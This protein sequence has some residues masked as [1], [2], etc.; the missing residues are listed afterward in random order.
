MLSVVNSTKDTWQELGFG[1]LQKS[2]ESTVLELASNREKG[3]VARS[4]LVQLTRE[5]RKS[6]SEETKKAVLALLKSFQAEVDA[7]RKR[8][9]YAEDAYIS[10]YKKLIDLPDPTLAL[11]E[12]QNLQ[13]KASRS[14]DI[15]CEN[16]KLRE[17]N[18]QLRSEVSAL[19]HHE[20][21]AARLQ[22][23]LDDLNSNMESELKSR[24]ASLEENFKKTVLE[25]EQE[26]IV[27]R[28]EMEEKHKIMEEK[29]VGLTKALEMTQS[30][31]FTLKTQAD[32][33]ESGKTSELEILTD[34]LDKAR[35]RIR[36]LE[37]SLS[38][39][40]TGR[41][42]NENITSQ[43]LILTSRVEDLESDLS[44]KETEISLY[45]S[46]L[47]VLRQEKEEVQS[48]LQVKVEELQTLITNLETQ[49][50]EARVRLQSQSDYEE[51]C[52]ELAFLRSIEF[53]D[54]N[55]ISER[56]EPEGIAQFD[57]N[58]P[59]ASAPVLK[60]PL[61]VLLMNKNRALQNQIA[62]L[63]ATTDQ[64]RAELHRLQ[65]FEVE[66]RQQAQEQRELIAVL[67][68]DLYRL[69]EAYDEAQ[70]LNMFGQTGT[71]SQDSLHTASHAAGRE[72][73]ILAEAIGE[74]QPN[75]TTVP[76]VDPSLLQIVVHQRDRFRAR[77]EELEQSES[78]HKQQI[79]LLQRE[80]ESVRADNVK[81]YG[82]IRF[83][84]SYSSPR[85]N[86]PAPESTKSTSVAIP[87]NQDSVVEKYS[88]AYEADLDP[89]SQFH[90]QERQRHYRD[91]RPHD[92][93][94]LKVFRLVVGNRTARLGAFVYALILHLLVFLALYKAAHFQ[95]TAN[96]AEANCLQRYA[97]HMRLVHKEGAPDGHL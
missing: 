34:E 55:L 44:Q 77:T 71:P 58:D 54:E 42:D 39:S 95:T 61:E 45:A 13:K 23:L 18:E 10:V 88:Q 85:H 92:K 93:L 14:T 32:T 7:S 59:A 15:E 17:T 5:F 70:R 35:E 11:T 63:S 25:R 91:L 84:Q 16:R 49:L 68:S 89:F 1:D 29:T 47:S 74:E 36:E 52:R 48:S 50:S 76:R 75:Q 31:L 79:I 33:S 22:K 37:G 82:K 69:Q 21:E 41:S 6:A 46:K 64:L 24:K 96:E 38:P 97:E 51:V 65:M 2:L 53:S 90:R 9:A 4:N 27:L 72:G 19:R 57:S 26:L 66:S 3:D 43:V 73:Q 8:C 81:L 60:P 28:A 62:E 87:L 20:T 86:L 83:L 67:E 30:E 94:M 12:V 78:N 80:V 40:V 56:G